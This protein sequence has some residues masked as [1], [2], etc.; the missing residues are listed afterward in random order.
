VSNAVAEGLH[1]IGIPGDRIAVVHNVAAFTAG[2]DTTPRTGA[3]AAADERDGGVAGA[4]RC[5]TVVTVGRLTE[6]KGYPVLLEAVRDLPDVVLLVA[7]DGPLRRELEQLAVGLGVADRVRFLGHV[8]DVAGLLDRGDLFALTSLNEGL[9]LVVVEAMVAGLPVVASRVGGTPE[10]VVDGETGLLV[11]PGDVLAT[12]AAIRRLLDDPDLA[13]RMGRRGQEVARERFSPAALVEGVLRVYED[14]LDGH[15]RA[16]VRLRRA[17]LGRRGSTS[18]VAVAPPRLDAAPRRLDAARNRALRRADWRFLLPDPRP[19]TVVCYAGGSL[20][21]AALLV[22][23]RLVEPG[24]AIGGCDLAVVADPDAELLGAAW[25]ALRPAGVLYGEWRRAG[26]MLPGAIVRQLEQAGFSDARRYRP[27]PNLA[28]AR[29]WLPLDSAAA[30]AFY[31]GQR[32]PSGRGPRRIARRLARRVVAGIVAAGLAPPIAVI[33]RKAMASEPAGPEVP[34]PSSIGPIDP[35][36]LEGA[37][38]GSPARGAWL[39]VTGG[40]RTISKGVGLV[41]VDGGPSP[42]LAVK[43]N[44]TPEARPRVAHEADVLASI[45]VARPDLPGI[46]RIRRR[47]ERADLLL[48]G[49]SPVIG[50]RL[51]ASIARA[52]FP[53]RAALVTDWLTR[54]AGPTRAVPRERWFERLVTPVAA[55]FEQDFGTVLADHDVRASH[56]LLAA[57]P[58]L[59][60]VLEQRDMGPWNL[61][62]AADGGLGVVDWES[63]EPEGLPALDLVYFLVYAAFQV[64]GAPFHLDGAGRIGS[65]LDAYRRTR[66]PRTGVGQVAQ[67]SLRRYC[68][69]VGVDPAALPALHALAW[70]IHARSESQRLREDAGGAPGQAALRAALMPALWKAE[71]AM[72]GP[73]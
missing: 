57:L 64:E 27:W 24:S 3:T 42:R 39:L 20:R 26:A 13:R 12:R 30:I 48:L 4:S 60:L 19:D 9:P 1:G 2:T 15:A 33:A 6:Q 21:H 56:E 32:A 25:L 16:A 18:L 22:G 59:P 70:M 73:S 40:P 35:S 69:G 58:A 51:D 34:R 36:W 68:A 55:A 38:G 7:G 44:R 10:A 49:E 62:L 46:P 28:S 63:A 45:E 29:A 5:R 67:V 31:F 41:F 11:D 54:L 71:L 72:A 8:D 50:T 17:L 65:V 52:T 37:A 47:E 43:M 23:D 66:D 14:A 53:A 61:L